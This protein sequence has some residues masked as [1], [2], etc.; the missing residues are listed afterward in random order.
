MLSIS[1]WNITWD[2]TTMTTNF[3]KI[4]DNQVTNL[5]KASMTANWVIDD[6]TPLMSVMW[7]D[8]MN[9]NNMSTFLLVPKSVS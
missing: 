7:G 3:T 4:G 6:D 8:S 2:N 9:A 5:A 1:T